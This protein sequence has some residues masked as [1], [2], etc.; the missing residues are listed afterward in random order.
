[1]SGYARGKHPASRRKPGVILHRHARNNTGC[2]GVS[3]N[4]KH[5]PQGDRR[6]FQICLGRRRRQFPIDSL[7]LREA[8]RRAVAARAEY[9]RKIVDMVRNC[10]KKR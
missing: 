4:T 6:F 8:F 5:L 7:G 1:M 2:V 10:A 3:F 9:E